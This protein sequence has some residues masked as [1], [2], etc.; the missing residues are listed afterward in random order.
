MSRSLLTFTASLVIVAV[1]FCA[2][3]FGRD[4]LIPFAVAIM[5]WYLLNA[6]AGGYGRVR[7]ADWSPPAW[8]CMTASILT[9]TVALAV[10]FMLIRNNVVA[11]SEAAPQYQ[12][13]LQE[14]V[15]R[16]SGWVGVTEPPRLRDVFRQFDLATLI[17]GFAETATR[18]ASSAG[19]ILIYVLFL[20]IEQRVFERKLS[21]LLPDPA[22]EASAR[23]LLHRIQERIETYVW[24]KTLTSLLT[25]GISY[26]ILVS[27]GVDYAA[28]LGAG[29]L[30]AEL[31]P[32]H[33]LPA[34]HR[35]SDP[36]DDHPVRQLHAVPGRP[37][38]AGRDPGDDRQL[39]RAADD[40]QLAQCQPAG[41]DPVACPVG[42]HLGHCRD[43]AVRAVH[44][45][46][47]DHLRPLPTDPQG[48]P[49]PLPERQYLCGDPESVGAF[50][51]FHR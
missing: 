49:A 22:H 27:V 28:L 40:G 8:L 48:R 47:D 18:I 26:L 19:V 45:D 5:I 6:L 25:G 1:I 23:E 13:N 43:A 34:R 29:D 2:L 4:L 32:D 20:L 33:R 37:G 30:H 15:L 42:Q 14:L 36:A 12:A 50:A 24:I 31:H 17:T 41:G 7:I 39:S 35:L 11:V 9:V 44:R 46:R 3:I 51:P 38:A 21:A 16:V 10:V